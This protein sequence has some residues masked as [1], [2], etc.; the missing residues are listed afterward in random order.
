MIRIAIDGPGGAG[1]SSL[2]KAVAKELK[3]IYVDT[4]ALYRT[5]GY[6]MLNH[7]IDPTDEAAV[8][9]ELGK[10]KL[11][12]TYVDGEQVILLD[13]ENVKD[14][15]R[16]PEI[17]MAASNVS[18]I[19]SVRD[20]LLD[21]QRDIAKQHSV[22][23]DG[24]DIGTVILP[25]AEVK[26]FLTASPEA[27]AKRRYEELKAKGK[28]VS[29][30]Q[31]YAEMV[32]RD[33]NDSTR[34]I[35]PCI[36]AKDAIRLDNSGMTPE[37]TVAAVIDII[38]KAQKGQKTTFYMRAHAILAPVI[39][40]FTGVKSH[41]VEN[42]PKEG[43]FLLCANHIAVRDVILIGVTCPRQIKFVAKKE[44]FSV[45]ILKT[46]ITA[47]GA[48]KL[49][50]GGNDVA[51]MRKSVE[52]AENGDIVSIFPQGHRYPAVDPSKTPIKNGAGMIAY[53]AG[54]DVIPVF[55]K[56]KGN[57]YGIFKRVEIFYGKPIKNSELGFTKGGSDEYKAA[58]D[59]IFA[60]LL[61]LGGY[62][63]DPDKKEQNLEG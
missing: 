36:P 39:R 22:I 5:I 3:I 47:M 62:S 19:K 30:D 1:K 50:R 41:G 48:V 56:T 21:T 25:K 13:G 23:M 55:I 10:F 58:T 54:C 4:G 61:D 33:T 59:M 15:I 49:D 43:G 17:S 35:A 51:A 60:R 44:L 42:I 45:P 53:R 14:V 12:L 24:R 52:L 9:G 7:G 11:E 57:K 38:K 26:I 18:A 63:Y 40:F 2:A 31:V 20:F 28:E 32:E 27:R 29:Y 34:D 8:S 37:E 6:Y 46:V 16:T